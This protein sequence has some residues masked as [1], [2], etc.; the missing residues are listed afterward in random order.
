MKTLMLVLTFGFAI[1]NCAANSFG[2]EN[3]G[4]ISNKSS[5]QSPELCVSVGEEMP[6]LGLWC[7]KHGFQRGAVFHQEK[8]SL[9]RFYI[10]HDS[11]CFQINYI[12]K[13]NK[14]E[15]ISLG[16]GASANAKLH[17]KIDKITFHRNSSYTL[18][19]L[20]TSNRPYVVRPIAPGDIN[21]KNSFRPE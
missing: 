16:T 14:V 4:E 17:T 2:Q 8:S 11:L 10:P 20:P 18:Q 1:T 21:E 7:D 3:T 13:T 15:R 12:K 19:F 6:D 5:D 9:F